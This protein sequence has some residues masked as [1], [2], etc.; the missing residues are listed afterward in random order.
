MKEVQIRTGARKN[1][2]AANPTGHEDL[3][4]GFGPAR[5]SVF[6]LAT[7]VPAIPALSRANLILVKH[8]AAQA[9][10]HPRTGPAAAHQHDQGSPMSERILTSI[11][12]MVEQ[13]P[14]VNNRE[15]FEQLWAIPRRW[16]K[17]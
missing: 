3:L 1:A 13:S 12:E 4:L 14:N 6:S 15:V 2:V 16:M 9:V 7:L 8:G 11:I 5:F 10:Y 17:R